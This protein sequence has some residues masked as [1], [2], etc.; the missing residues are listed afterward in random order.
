MKAKVLEL[1]KNWLSNA[2]MQSVGLAAWSSG[3]R[4]L[5]VWLPLSW[6]HV[7]SKKK[8]NVRGTEAAANQGCEQ[9]LKQGWKRHAWG[10]VLGCRSM[11]PE[12]TIF[13]VIWNF[14]IVVHIETNKNKSE[15]LQLCMKPCHLVD[16]LYLSSYCMNQYC[17]IKS[18]WKMLNSVLFF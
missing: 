3:V 6:H 13:I 10:R 9:P 16:W 1:T 7:A 14:R 8:H 17:N 2:S 11:K 18:F 12:N 5:T 15:I 4:M